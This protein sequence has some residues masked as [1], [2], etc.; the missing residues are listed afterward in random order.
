MVVAAVI[1]DAVALHCTAGKE[2]DLT[3]PCGVCLFFSS[4]V[5]EKLWKVILLWKR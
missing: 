3:C 2:V 4:G 1:T 5:E